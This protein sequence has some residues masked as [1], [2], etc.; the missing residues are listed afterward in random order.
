DAHT[1]KPQNPLPVKAKKIKSMVFSPDGSTLACASW[2][3]TGQFIFSESD[4]E[5]YESIYSYI[6]VWDTRTGRHKFNLHADFFLGFSPDGQM[7]A[8]RINGDSVALW[9]ANTGSC[10]FTFTHYPS[11]VLYPYPTPPPHSYTDTSA[12]GSATSL[13]FSPNGL[14]LASF[15]DDTI[16]L[17]DYHT[18]NC[19]STFTGPDY[20]TSLV[21]S[22]DG[23]TLAGGCKDGTVLLWHTDADNVLTTHTKGRF[24]YH[25]YLKSDRWQR[26][27]KSVLTRDNELCICGAKATEVHHKTY[28]RV[29]HE[30]PSDLVSLCRSC[31]QNVHDNHQIDQ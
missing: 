2:V 17:W 11:S 15:S 19:K 3:G 4:G 6:D 18:G 21:F 5:T 16:H 27:R 20:I 31:H 22:P 14:T 13:A 8:G 1:G 10:K 7:L 28:A 29:G 12:L 9:E 24:D 30:I 25:E 26:L 23:S